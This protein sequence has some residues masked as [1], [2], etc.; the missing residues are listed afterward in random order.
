[1]DE[2]RIVEFPKG[3]FY[4][5]KK[6]TKVTRIEEKKWFK[7]KITIRENKE[8]CSLDRD[9]NKAF[10]LIGHQPNFYNKMPPARFSSLKEARDFVDS[11]SNYP[12][13][14]SI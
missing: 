12:K 10:H 9:G 7:T 6:F 1:M 13:Y 8:W 14:Y 11:I 3:C 2:Y 4:A 5:E